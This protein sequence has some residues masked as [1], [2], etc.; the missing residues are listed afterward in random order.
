MCIILTVASECNMKE[1]HSNPLPLY[2]KWSYL[3]GGKLWIDLV[4]RV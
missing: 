2:L 3:C 4:V 1:G